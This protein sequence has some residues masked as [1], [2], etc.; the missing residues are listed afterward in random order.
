MQQNGVRFPCAIF[1]SS[2]MRLII[3]LLACLS[4]SWA[5]AQ[6]I[7]TENKRLDQKDGWSGHIDFGISLTQNTKQILQGSNAIQAQYHKKKNT[8]L[9]INDLRLMQVDRSDLLNRGYQHV[10]YN[11]ELRPYLIPECFV[12]AQ[13]DQ[14]WKLDY[15]LLAGAGPRFKLLQNDSARIFTGTLAMLEYE[16]VDGGS[17]INSDVRMSTYLSGSYNWPNHF[18]IDHITYFQPLV[19]DLRDFRI[20]S[21]TNL[22]VAF[23]KHLGLKVGFGLNYDAEPPP[24]LPTLIYNLNN[25]IS[26]IF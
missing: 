10:R 13:Y 20:S 21:E 6:V 12:Q 8:L 23:T 3:M 5:C 25:S 18:G 1:I 24:G 19:T 2:N 17:Q 16:Q 14:I 22:R 9:L 26:Y 7:N 4:A 11:Y 15:R